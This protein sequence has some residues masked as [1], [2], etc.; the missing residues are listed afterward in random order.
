MTTPF[1]KYCGDEY[2]HGNVFMKTKYEYLC[3]CA[4]DPSR[5]R[6]VRDAY[7]RAYMWSKQKLIWEQQNAFTNAV[8]VY[9]QLS[10]GN[11]ALKRA[12]N[13]TEIDQV[14]DM[15]RKRRPF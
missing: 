3:P 1:A 2:K 6:S 9:V 4:S 12:T 10:N 11:R 14:Y 15:L 7:R 5:Y 8:M 13:E